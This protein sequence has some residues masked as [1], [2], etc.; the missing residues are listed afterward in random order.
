MTD[1]QPTEI[2]VVLWLRP[3]VHKHTERTNSVTT[4][5]GVML[6]RRDKSFS[7]VGNQTIEVLP[8]V[9]ILPVTSLN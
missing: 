4:T 3:S 5:E 7:G 6:N 8:V 2:D 9:L 1:K